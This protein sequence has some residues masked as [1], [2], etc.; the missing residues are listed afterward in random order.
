MFSLS[1]PISYSV[2]VTATAINTLSSAEANYWLVGIILAMGCAFAVATLAYRRSIKTTLHTEINEQLPAIEKLINNGYQILG[3]FE[4]RM[5]DYS[6][7]LGQQDVKY[8][9]TAKKIISALEARYTQV[10]KLMS[11]NNYRDML[12]AHTLLCSDLVFNNN[13]IFNLVESAPLKP[14]T[15]EEWA[16]TLEELFTDFERHAA[17]FQPSI[18]KT[19]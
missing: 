8:L 5:Y 11:N 3:F 4:R 6:E 9:V 12:A 16:P 10:V 18:R 15:P 14:L 1:N 2:V 7:A 17:V 13:G 19:A